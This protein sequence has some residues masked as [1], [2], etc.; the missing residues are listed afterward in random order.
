MDTYVVVIKI[1]KGEGWTRITSNKNKTPGQVMSR[2]RVYWTV[3][4]EDGFAFFVCA[5]MSGDLGNSTW[6]EET[7]RINL[8]A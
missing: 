6:K 7:K 5:A 2:M 8:P 3:M 1:T 4:L